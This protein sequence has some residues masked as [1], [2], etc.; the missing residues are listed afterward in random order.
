M[1]AQTVVSGSVVTSSNEPLAGATV[2]FAK[3]DSIAGGAATDS[4]GRFQVKGLPAGDYECRVSMIGY[5]PAT[6]KFTLTEKTKLPQF[7][8]DEDAKALDEV[9]VSVDARELTKERAGMSVYYLSER[10][11]NE[12]NAYDALKEIPR[13]LIDPVSRTIMFD[14]RRTP[15][16][17]ING[18]KKPLSVIDPKIIE[19]VEVIDNPSARYRGDMGVE[20]VLNIK[21]KKDGIQPYI[22][23]EVGVISM[24][25][26][27]FMWNEGNLETGSETSSFYAHAIYEQTKNVFTDTYSDITQGNIHRVESTKNKNYNDNPSFNLGGDKEFSKKDY[28]A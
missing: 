1:V 17:L 23:G 3:S 26:N 14:D 11:K 21:T 6:Q 15:L 20:A 25:N 8:L 5:K 9:T 10:A 28:I 13:L 18:I 22:K 2:L 19:S 12:K 7:V 4:K 27:N 16:V 24:L